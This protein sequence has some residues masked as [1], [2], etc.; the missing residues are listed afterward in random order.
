M[1]S[2]QSTMFL[3]N[4]LME[5]LQALG[6]F[7]GGVVLARIMF[8]LFKRVFKRL[9]AKTATKSNRSNSSRADAHT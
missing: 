2:L 7:L 6:F 1:D 4:P 5:W 8:L 3:G 9:A